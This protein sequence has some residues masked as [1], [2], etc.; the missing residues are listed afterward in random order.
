MDDLSVGW[1]DCWLS[2]VLEARRKSCCDQCKQ[3]KALSEGKQK[4][5]LPHRLHLL[6]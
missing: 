2:G 6:H 4:N 3:W 5:L 1:L